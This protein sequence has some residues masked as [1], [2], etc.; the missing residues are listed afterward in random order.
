MGKRTYR[1][2]WEKDYDWLAL[3]K[4]DHHKAYCKRCAKT[5]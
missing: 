3:V 1:A 4:T 2:A 5:F